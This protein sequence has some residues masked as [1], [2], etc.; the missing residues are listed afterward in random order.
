MSERRRIHAPGPGLA[1]DEG[2]RMESRAGGQD[3]V[4]DDIAGRRID[5]PVRSEVI[6]AGGIAPTFLPSEP[7]LGDG[8][9]RFAQE[10]DHPAAGN[11]GG[12]DGSDAFRLIIPPVTSPG[13]MQGHR[14]QHRPGEVTSEDLVRQC[15]GRKIISQEGAVLI[16]DAMDDAPGRPPGAEGAD[17]PAEGGSEVEA[18]RAGPVTFQDTFEGVTAREAAGVA[19][20]GEQ[21]G[22]GR[23]QVRLAA[24]VHGFHRHRAVPGKDQVEQTAVQV[25]EPPVHASAPDCVCP[26]LRSNQG[27]P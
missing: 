21:V 25:I 26:T 23:G 13:G 6:G 27:L 2:A 7:G 16:L 4:D 15:D 12:E 18:V 5:R 19:D 8:L 20:P 10:I 11:L 9:V 1:E 24:F 3:I 14:D 17:R 22:P